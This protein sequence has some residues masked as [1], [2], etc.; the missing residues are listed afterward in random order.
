MICRHVL[1][2]VSGTLTDEWTPMALREAICQLRKSNPKKWIKALCDLGVEVEED[3][4]SCLN[5]L[6]GNWSECPLF[7]PRGSKRESEDKPINE[8]GYPLQY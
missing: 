5:F 1:V 8:Y 6:D 2:V 7:A 3:D 4:C